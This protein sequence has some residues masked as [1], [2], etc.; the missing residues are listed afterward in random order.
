MRKCFLVMCMLLFMLILMGSASADWFSATMP[1][2]SLISE[3]TTLIGLGAAMVALG[4]YGRRSL[5]KDHSR[6]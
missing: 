6:D 5:S 4:A 3:H 1:A 2:K